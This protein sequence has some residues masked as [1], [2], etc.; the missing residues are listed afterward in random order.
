MLCFRKD[1]EEQEGPKQSALAERSVHGRL[2]KKMA[3]LTKKP[4]KNPRAVQ[5]ATR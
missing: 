1:T 5:M 4:S 2:N 3:E